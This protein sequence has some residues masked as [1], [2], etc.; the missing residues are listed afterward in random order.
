M[1]NDTPSQSHSSKPAATGGSAPPFVTISRQIGIRFPSLPQLVAKALSATPSTNQPA[2]SAWDR[3]IIAKA[4]AEHDLREQSIEYV[5]QSGYSWLDTFVSG[6]GGCPRRFWH[7]AST[8]RHG[9]TLGRTG[10]CCAGRARRRVHD[11]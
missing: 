10:A 8:A 5:E 6:L 11:P 1:L 4:V 2:W 3:E 7:C 9:A